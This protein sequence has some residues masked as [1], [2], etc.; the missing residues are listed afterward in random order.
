MRAPLLN[1]TVKSL[2]ARL[3][4]V[5]L[6]RCVFPVAVICVEGAYHGH[7]SSCI[8]VSPYKF[9]NKGI[10]YCFCLSSLLLSLFSLVP[11]MSDALSHDRGCVCGLWV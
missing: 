9:N 11:L 4:Y 6:W 5:L 2:L 3:L 8:E 10:S 7:T 1:C